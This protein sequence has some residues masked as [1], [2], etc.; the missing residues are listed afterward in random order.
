[1]AFNFPASWGPFP[2]AQFPYTQTGALNMDWVICVVKNLI[3]DW[4]QT[5]QDWKTQ[6]E[7][8]DSLKSYVENY[9]K[10]LDVQDEI[11][12]KLDQLWEDGTLGSLFTEA[13]CINTVR[14]FGAK[15]NAN[16]YNAGTNTWYAT[17]DFTEQAQDDTDYIQATVNAAVENGY[18][19]LI[20]AG[21]YLITKPINI[22]THMTVFGSGTNSTVIVPAHSFS[23]YCINI[24]ANTSG[25]DAI[26]NVNVHDIS[27]DATHSENARGIN[28]LFL[29]YN[30]SFK[31]ILFS[32][33][34]N[35][36]FNFAAGDDA[37]ENIVF[38]NI[39]VYPNSSGIKT[40][41][42]VLNRLHETMFRNL[43]L[44]NFYSGVPYPTSA[45]P[46][47]V[48]DAVQGVSFVNCDFF[49]C[50]GQP[51]VSIDGYN[52]LFFNSCTFESNTGESII[53]LKANS[54]D[55]GSFFSFYGNR[56]N[57]GTYAISIANTSAAYVCD[58]FVT[59][60]TS[61]SIYT[62]FF[63]V[64][65]FT[66]TAARSLVV[67]YDNTD[68]RANLIVGGESDNAITLRTSNSSVELVP[69]TLTNTWNGIKAFAQYNNTDT[70]QLNICVN[71]KP[72]QVF[73][74]NGIVFNAVDELPTAGYLWRYQIVI[75]NNTLYI[76]VQTDGGAWVWKQIMFAE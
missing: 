64:R 51:C 45:A 17:S 44:V 42:F 22:I 62:S 31:N 57:V 47:I 3:A 49:Y 40:S 25:S 66:G 19:V 23:D 18:P 61:G 69:P 10:N 43:H 33:F 53:E 71:G 72:V 13:T 12:N 4:K 16:Y 41:W 7:A 21:R 38:E 55:D 39:L 14:A 63:F 54:I 75:M 5:A 36:V 1:M 2:G 20:P 15:G 27:F 30:S 9:F 73:G 68:N 50:N 56:R 70:S 65:S 6:Q 24:Q 34:G 37:S 35:T 32:R 74:I 46:M 58:P 67:R 59:V 8:F 52:G 29:L 26:Q 60:N 11:N 76:C 28:A 48:G